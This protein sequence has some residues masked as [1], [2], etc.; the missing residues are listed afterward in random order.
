MGQPL[1]ET[2]I[3]THA[4]MFLPTGV[5]VPP[6]D[7][8]SHLTE[9]R[10]LIDR[11]LYEQATLL[12]FKLSGREDYRYSNPF[13]P[14]FDMRIATTATGAVRDYLRGVDFQTGVAS[15]HWADE[16]GV[17]E[18]RLFVSRADGVA[19][20]LITGPGKGSIDCTMKLASC[21][22]GPKV[23]E[24]LVKQSN[25]G[26]TQNGNLPSAIATLLRGNTPELMLSYT[27][28]LESLVPNM[29]V[30][31]RQSPG[32]RAQDAAGFGAWRS[33]VA[34]CLAQGVAHWHPG[35]HAV[36]GP[37]RS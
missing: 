37:D 7:T 22:P 4:R 31:A 27:R 10:Q 24:N 18:R 14:A 35:R 17:F 2:I 20:L 30:N 28:Y 5:P 8:A 6:P 1:D 3:F 34:A 15:V 21:Q 25:S 12:G 11:G 36:P 13:V 23:R 9:M 19:V 29:R 16:R 33:Q 32:A 26:F